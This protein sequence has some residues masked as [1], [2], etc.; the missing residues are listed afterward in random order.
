MP[1]T[2]EGLILS[3]LW[4]S[5]LKVLFP[6]TLGPSSE[7]TQG[8]IVANRDSILC[9]DKQFLLLTSACSICGAMHVSLMRVPIPT[10]L[11]ESMQQSELWVTRCCRPLLLLSRLLSG[12]L[13]LLS[14]LLL[15]LSLE[16]AAANVVIGDIATAA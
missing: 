11:F 16:V 2:G 4:L 15:L 6:G 12:R 8:P 5:S 14:L 10:N 3:N 7:A 1:P 13:Y 9:I